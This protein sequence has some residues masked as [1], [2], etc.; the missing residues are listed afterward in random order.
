MKLIKLTTLEKRDIAIVADEVVSIEE[1]DYLDWELERK[2]DFRERPTRIIL[3]HHV[4][5]VRED[6]ETVCALMKGADDEDN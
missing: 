6:F 2:Y 1:E 5:V 3:K 4:F